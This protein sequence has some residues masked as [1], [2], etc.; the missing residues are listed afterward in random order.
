MIPAFEANND[1]KMRVELIPRNLWGS[2][3]RTLLRPAT[4]NRL[5]KACYEKAGHVCE[6][7]GHTGLEQGRKHK[8]EAHERWEYNDTTNTQTYRGLIA[9]C[10]RH[11]EVA[12]IGRALATGRGGRAIQ[13]LAITNDS[14]IAET[15]EYVSQ[16]MMIHMIRSQRGDWSLNLQDLLKEEALTDWD[17]ER[18][19]LEVLI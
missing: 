10:P 17:R 13:L 12:H 7:C 11:H 15:E 8:V 6:V 5:R 3:L 9:L 1:L 14:T 4:W 19:P 16:C 2:N 18:L